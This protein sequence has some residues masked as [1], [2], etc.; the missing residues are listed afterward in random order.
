MKYIVL[1]PLNHNKKLYPAGAEVE[2]GKEE[3][4]ALLAVAAIEPV[5]KTE[6]QTDKP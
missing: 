1:T 4:D 2:L 6:K 5:K 3:A